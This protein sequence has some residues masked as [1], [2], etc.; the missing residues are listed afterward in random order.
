MLESRAAAAE[1]GSSW[2]GLGSDWLAS[3][4]AGEFP[5]PEKSDSGLFVAFGEGAPPDDTSLSSALSGAAFPCASC[6]FSSAF[7]LKASVPLSLS[8]PITRSS[9]EVRGRRA[10][11]AAPAATARTPTNK[12]WSRNIWS[13]ARMAEATTC[14]FGSVSAGVAY[15][16]HGIT[17]TRGHSVAS[18]PGTLG[19]IMRRRAEAAGC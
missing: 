19:G 5:P 7:S 15:P 9:A 6:S 3:V 14:A 8:S 16:V 18:F 12:G 17:G 10:P 2:G 1:V 11:R 13:F 4:P